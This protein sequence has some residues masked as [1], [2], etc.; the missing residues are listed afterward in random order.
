MQLRNLGKIGQSKPSIHSKTKKN[1]LEKIQ[2]CNKDIF[3]G[4]LIPW[5]KKNT[6]YV[7]SYTDQEKQEEMRW[8]VKAYHP[9]IE[10]NKRIL[11]IIVCEK[12][13]IM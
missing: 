11:K 9:D 4:R 8:I 1:R 12:C 7:L 10:N 6:W 2:T 3:N 13:L 5:E